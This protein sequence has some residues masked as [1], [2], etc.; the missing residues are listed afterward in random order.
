MTLLLDTHVFLWWVN[1]APIS[2]RA[3]EYLAAREHE[4]LF[5]AASAWEMTIK[6]SIG[7]LT[8]P[9]PV[10]TFV[11]KNLALNGFRWFGIEP[12]ALS[13]LQGLHYHHRDPFDR[14]LIAQAIALGCP[15]LS[16]DPLFHFYPVQCIWQ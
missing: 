15:L 7:K 9:E 6:A 14:L 13:V 5:S 11:Q 1:G 12:E 2:A 10:A 3:A 8:V 16:A 4:I